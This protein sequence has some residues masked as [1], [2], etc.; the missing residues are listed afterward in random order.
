MVLSSVGLPE[1]SRYMLR[2][3]AWGARSRKSMNVA[4]PSARRTSMKPPPPMFPAAGWVTAR[5]N[6][7][8]TA[9]S[10]A[11]P[12][13]RRTATPAWVAWRSRATPMA[14]R[15]RTGCAPHAGMPAA[16]TSTVAQTLSLPR[17]DSSGRSFPLRP[18]DLDSTV[19]SPLRPPSPPFEKHHAR[20]HRHIQRRNPAR[21]GDA[22]QRVAMLPHL[23]VQAFA[24]AA[25]H[26]RRRRGVLHLVVRL[27]AALI[28]AVDPEAPLFDFFERPVDIGDAHHRQVFERAGRGLGHHV[29]DAGRAPFRNHHRARARGVGRPDDGAQVVRIFDAVEHHQHF[30]WGHAVE[31]GIPPSGAHGHHALVR[32]GA[33]QAV[34]RRAR[35]KAHGYRS[36]P[37]QIDDFLQPRAAGAL[38]YQQALERVLRPQS[39]RHRM[40]A[41][42][43]RHFYESSSW[44][45]LM[46]SI[47]PST[48]SNSPS[49]PGGSQRISW[50]IAF[51]GSPSNSLTRKKISSMVSLPG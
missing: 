37:R 26:H 50:N 51:R 44:F 25:Q 35:L 41:A 31:V 18:I 3:A 12:P 34:E 46:N 6:P 4:R 29:G 23:L 11:L 5:A 9:A 45:A 33:G 49:F 14:C 8:A 28:Q 47:S 13:A 42:Q 36:A 19:L 48:K 30:A 16:I 20:C 24:L 15:A 40:N 1:E 43:Y 32:R 10:T 39:L 22:H 38:R 7:T 21:H 27:V 17:P 2:E